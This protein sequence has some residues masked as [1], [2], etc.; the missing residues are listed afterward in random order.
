MS[1]SHARLGPSSSSRW[2]YCP[3]S[4]QL[5]ENIPETSAGPA[6]AAGT[7]MHTVFERLL[8]NQEHLTL[9]EIKCLRLLDVGEQR[10]RQIIDQG[11]QAARHTLV[12]YRLK[13]FLTE[14][15]VN[16][17]RRIGRDDF[18]GTADVVG[19]DAQRRILMV[20]DLKTGRGRVNVRNN[21]QLLSYGL[22]G[23]DLINFIPERVIFAI[24]QPPLWGAKP[25]LWETNFQA[26]LDFESHVSVQAEK[27]DRPGIP[28][29]PKD[30][31]CQW[32]PAKAVCPV[33]VAKQVT[34]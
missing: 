18:W 20:G 4:I 14:V 1:R 8:L 25:V 23:L 6:A 28:P 13:E 31:A 24:F 12:Q 5:A 9:D 3:A 30:E 26:L 15:R 34:R 32:C 16:P 21:T 10:A 2:L 11:V 33:F 27:T 7:L 17:G 29:T 22:G 19:A